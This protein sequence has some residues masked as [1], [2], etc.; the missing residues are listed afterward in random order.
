MLTNARR[1]HAVMVENVQTPEEA[2]LVHVLL[3]SKERIVEQV[4]EGRS[5]KKT[6]CC[7]HIFHK[8]NPCQLIT[9]EHPFYPETVT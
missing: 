9:I 2:T 4:Q 6:F 3:D 7:C 5:I 8:R 1:T